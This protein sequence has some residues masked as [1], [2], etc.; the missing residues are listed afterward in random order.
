M[1]TD[2]FIGPLVGVAKFALGGLLT[3]LFR[4]VSPVL[5]LPNVSPLMAT[6]LAGAK[7]Y[8]PWIAGLYGALSMIMLD[9]IMGA[10]GPWTI[11]TAAASAVVGVAGGY[12]LKGRPNRTRDYVALSIAGTLFFDITTG[13]LVAPLHGTSL[14]MA[15]LGQIPFT[16]YH[17]GG[18]VFF[19]LFAPI[20][21]EKIMKNPQI[22]LT[23]LARNA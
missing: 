14:G 17:L 16:M 23:L 20:F 10:I 11:Y 9:I 2:A 5:G 12:M 18:N 19:A 3:L 7:A 15:L 21:F 8:G 1:K 13:V 4:L 6:E 22:E